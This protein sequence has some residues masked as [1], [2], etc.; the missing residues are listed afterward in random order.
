MRLPTNPNERD[1]HYRDSP[2]NEGGAAAGH[3][4][5]ECHGRPAHRATRTRRRGDQAGCRGGQV[6]AE[7]SPSSRSS[8]AVRRLP[9]AITTGISRNAR[10]V[11]PLN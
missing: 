11:A 10:R 4:A 2:D 9:A 8:A 1:D 7:G 6:T 3:R 5:N